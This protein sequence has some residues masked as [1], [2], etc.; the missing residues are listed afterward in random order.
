[1]I[2]KRQRRFEGLLESCGEPLAEGEG[3]DR[4]LVNFIK[5]DLSVDEGTAIR[6]L[7]SI[8]KGIRQRLL[9][10]RV[11]KL[12]CGELSIEG[13]SPYWVQRLDRS[14]QQGTFDDAI[15]NTSLLNGDLKRGPVVVRIVFKGY[16]WF[17]KKINDV[18][19]ESYRENAKVYRETW[20]RWLKDTVSSRLL[21]Y[22]KF[23]EIRNYIWRKYE[24]AKEATDTV[25]G[26]EKGA[27]SSV[28]KSREA[29]EVGKD[30][31]SNDVYDDTTSVTDFHA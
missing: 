21:E 1:M 13:L 23:S 29:R 19:V 22:T 14:I 11:V 31:V 6:I 26:V 10:G 12:D 24:K 28:V 8:N 17:L 30:I 2:I 4:S 7:L 16:F 27:C 18:Q 25:P 5:E 15:E 20:V 3:L 9:A